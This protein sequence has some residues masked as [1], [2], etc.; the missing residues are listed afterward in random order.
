MPLPLVL[1][2]VRLVAAVGPLLDHLVQSPLVMLGPL[3]DLGLPW[4]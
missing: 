2:L 1:V 3:F 4:P